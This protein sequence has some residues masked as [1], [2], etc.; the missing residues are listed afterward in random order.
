[1][2]QSADPAEKTLPTAGRWATLLLA[3][4]IVLGCGWRLYGIAEFPSG[5]HQ[6][7]Q[8]D[9]ALLARIFWLEMVADQLGPA[10]KLWLSRQTKVIYE[11]P[12]TELLVAVGYVV[13]GGERPYL[14]YLLAT[15]CWLGGAPL[16]YQ[17]ASRLA[18]RRESGLV[19]VAYYLLAPLGIILS[20][21]FQPEAAMVFGFV[22]ALWWLVVRL[23]P[24]A[25]WGQTAVAGLVCGLTVA[26]KPGFA[27]FPLAATYATLRLQ[28][29]GLRRALREPQ[30]LLFGG[31]LVL[32]SLGYAYFFLAG[33]PG[34][35]FLPQL[36]LQANFYQGLGN[37][38]AA[39]VGW[40][41]LAAAV[42]GAVLLV[43]QRGSY[44]G[45]VLLSSYLLFCATFTYHTMTHSYY[46]AIA[47]V[48]VA[49]G[50][51]PLDLPLREA[52]RGLARWQTSV[53]GLVAIVAMWHF[54]AAALPITRRHPQFAE[55]VRFYQQLGEVCGRGS[56]VLCLDR[57]YGSA[58]QYHAWLVT[59]AWPTSADL[60]YG[61][62][63]GQVAE[64]VEE[65]LG[66]MV[67]QWS[68]D[69]FVV[70]DLA[71]LKRQSELAELLERRYRRHAGGPSALVFDLRAGAP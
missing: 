61:Q 1:M 52:C 56:V 38:I 42:I 68:P 33:H 25:G 13:T 21:S 49:V 59:A 10:E 57:N 12:L 3:T 37:Q 43:S 54:S 48:I 71:E 65:R 51:A 66:R 7:R 5:F 2:S 16:L 26:V 4:V 22:V 34:Q 30:W 23:P 41:W 60:A 50:I 70:T 55:Q 28:Q 62:L 9:G 29:L 11:P 46:H 63:R 53:C 14:A 45:L 58:L 18:G 44:V 47:I 69:F 67:K 20:R 15:A 17:V 40:Y 31:L 8:Y 19:A 24:R 32:P 35:K 27:F 36:L 64:P 6:T 39:A